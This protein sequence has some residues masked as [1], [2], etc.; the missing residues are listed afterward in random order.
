M[1]RRKSAGDIQASAT[2]VRRNSL[3]K[4][5][6]ISAA[7]SKMRDTII[8]SKLLERPVS[9]ASGLDDS[10][11]KIERV[12]LK[13]NRLGLMYGGLLKPKKAMAGKENVGR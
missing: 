7:L 9:L 6:K 4:D 10:G 1:G 12:G 11:N 5:N 8:N 13:E 3:G 2:P